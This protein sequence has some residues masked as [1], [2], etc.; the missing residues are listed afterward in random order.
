MPKIIT[1]TNLKG[2]VG[3]TATSVA[4]SCALASINRDNKA[5]LLIDLDPQANASKRLGAQNQANNICKA[6]LDPKGVK[7][8]D[9]VYEAL[10]GDEVIE[11]LYILP[12]SADRELATTQDII[13]TKPKRDE[14]L[15]RFIKANQEYFDNFD[16]VIIDTNPSLGI[17]TVNAM[18]VADELI[19]PVSTSADSYEA[20]VQSLQTAIDLHDVDDLSEINYRILRCMID[21]RSKTI[22]DLTERMASVHE[23]KMFKNHISKNIEFEKSEAL[24]KPV[25]ILYPNGKAQEEYLA[26]AQEIIAL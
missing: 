2:G 12:T 22:V 17:L 9:V 6:L 21:K 20:A 19:I 8:S 25:S 3:K 14:I 23:A 24:R 13:A 1:V 4:L 10:A 7:A 26:V 16:Y 11:N 15:A 5:I 18:T